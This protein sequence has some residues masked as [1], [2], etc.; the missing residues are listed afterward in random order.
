[1]QRTKEAQTNSQEATI[2]SK[3]K[4]EK[5]K[6]H[7]REQWGRVK[8]AGVFLVRIREKEESVTRDGVWVVFCFDW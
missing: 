5:S 8:F 3:V 7:E 4:W 2:H 1:M 6:Y